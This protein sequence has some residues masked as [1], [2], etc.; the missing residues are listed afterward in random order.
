MFRGNIRERCPIGLKICS[1]CYWK[2]KGTCTFP[3]EGYDDCRLPLE[4]KTVRLSTSRSRKNNN[5]TIYNGDD[6]NLDSSCSIEERIEMNEPI[7]SSYCPRCRGNLYPDMDTY[8]WYQYCLQCGYS[9]DLGTVN[10]ISA[11]TKRK[12]CGR[13]GRVTKASETSVLN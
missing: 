1:S 13:E 9:H 3:S 10:N 2:R 6:S 4:E 12:D 11:Q 5:D 8:G 7:Y